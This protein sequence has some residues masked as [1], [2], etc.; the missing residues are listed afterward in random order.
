MLGELTSK[1][2]AFVENYNGQAR[3]SVWVA[4]AESILAKIQHLCHNIF[5]GRPTRSGPMPTAPA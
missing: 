1:I 3:P 5:P 4:T 2:N